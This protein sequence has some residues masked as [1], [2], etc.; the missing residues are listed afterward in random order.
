MGKQRIDLL[1]SDYY[2]EHVTGVEVL[3]RLRRLFPDVPSIMVSG[4]DESSVVMEAVNRAGIRAFLRKPVDAEELLQT[5]R[6]LLDQSE[7]WHSN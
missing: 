4:A 7:N 3:E 6:R 5:I 2:L 1:V